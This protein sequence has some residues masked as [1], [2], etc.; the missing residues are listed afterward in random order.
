MLVIVFDQ[1]LFSVLKTRQS[2]LYSFWLDKD[3][4]GMK[5]QPGASSERTDAT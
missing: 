1:I 4:N 3:D 5:T 2:P